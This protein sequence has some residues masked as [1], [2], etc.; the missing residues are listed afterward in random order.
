MFDVLKWSHQKLK[1]LHLDRQRKLSLLQ[2]LEA[3]VEIADPKI[4]QASCYRTE[5]LGPVETALS[6]Y[7]QLVRS[8]P[9]PVCL[10]RK[11]YAENPLVKALFRSI[12]EMEKVLREALNSADPDVNGREVFALMTMIKTETVV[13]GHKQQGSMILADVP[14]RAVTFVDHNIIAPFPELQTTMSKLPEYGLEVLAEVAMENIS[15]LRADLAELR[16]RRLRLSSMQSILSGK[17]TTS[18]FF[19]LPEKEN[20]TKLRELQTLL[21]ETEREIDAAKQKIETPEKALGHLRH[22][23]ASPESVLTLRPQSLKLNWM[24]VIVEDSGEPFHK[25]DL[26]EFSLNEDLRRSAI[27]VS[28]DRDGIP[29]K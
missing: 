27:L 24:N 10:N 22:I 3:V 11:N 15:S 14:M 29:A 20:I 6:Y 13:F 26:A 25:I 19:A 17:C 21:D 16:E 9:G 4:R 5:L 18:M 1:E 28:F 12:E 23:M 2:P 7:V 8:I